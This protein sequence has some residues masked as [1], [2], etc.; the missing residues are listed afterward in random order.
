VQELAREQP[1]LKEAFRPV[2]SALFQAAAFA[3]I[4]THRQVV[5][6]KVGLGPVG[7]FFR[8]VSRQL[9]FERRCTTVRRWTITARRPTRRVSRVP[10]RVPRRRRASARSPGQPRPD[11]D[12]EPPLGARRCH[13]EGARP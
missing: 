12:P 7:N 6:G 4:E 1:E 8:S 10:R 11:E 2:E 3:S 13:P 9:A 5:R